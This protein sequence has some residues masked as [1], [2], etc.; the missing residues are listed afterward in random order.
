MPP[1]TLLPSPAPGPDAGLE[2]HPAIDVVV[3]VYNEQARRSSRR[4]PPPARFLA[5][6]LPV[7]LADRRSPTTRAPT[8]RRAIAAR[9]GRRRCRGVAVAAPRPQK[10]RGRALRAAWSA[11]RRATSSA[12]MDV[13]LSTDL[14]A[15][16]PLVAPLLSGHS[17]VAIGTRLARGARVVRGAKRELISRAYNRSCC[18]RRCG[19]RFSDAQCGFKAVRAR[20]RSPAARRRARRRLVL[21]HRAARAR[22]AARACASTRCRSTGSTTPTRAWTSCAPRSTTCAASRGCWRGAR[23]IARFIGGRRRSHARLRA[24]LPAAARRRSAPAGAN[25]ARAGDHRRRQHRGQPPPHVRRPRPRRASC[26]ST[27]AARSSSCSR[28][29]LTTGA[30]A[31]PARPRRRARRAAVE[32]AVLVVA[33]DRARPSPA[34]SRCA[35]WVFARG[36]RTGARG[37]WPWRSTAP[38]PDRPTP[39]HPIRPPPIRRRDP[40]T[41]STSSVTPP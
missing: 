39:V 3:P 12:Y 2:A 4:D 33:G 1:A 29:A 5:P 28:S 25:A 27:R 11:Q 16:L 31:R 17:D 15:L 30:L 20:R 38:T 19:A 32:L 7:H 14:R 26:A 23:L 37:A 24:A 8:P 13:D 35:R 10:G 36:Q 22:P 9:A 34:T 21:R 41:V 6:S 18:T 40:A